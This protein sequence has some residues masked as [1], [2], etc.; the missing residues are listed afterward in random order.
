MVNAPASSGRASGRAGGAGAQ[1]ALLLLLAGTLAGGPACE[2]TPPRPAQPAAPELNLTTLDGV[3]LRLADYR[4]QVV[5][6]DFWATWCGPCR[7]EI[8]HLI[9]L[10][11]EF[12]PRGFQIIG[13]AVSDREDSV[14]LFAERMNLNYVTAMGTQD[15][16]DAYGGFTAIPT[17][18]LLAPDGTIAARYTGYQEK[19]VF[20]EAIQKLLVAR[21]P[22]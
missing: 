1:R 16:V 8:P 9:E 14:R 6:L 7:L 21:E 12:G 2:R 4:G 11:R 10:Q 18:F 13:V 22:S 5:L 20:A 19:Q 15:V 3:P 17:T